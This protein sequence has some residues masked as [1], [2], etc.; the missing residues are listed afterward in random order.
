MHTLCQASRET[1][2]FLPSPGLQEVVVQ[3]TNE[4]LGEKI[5]P[6]FEVLVLSDLEQSKRWY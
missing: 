4:V 3:P 5:S 6:A 1:K 2:R